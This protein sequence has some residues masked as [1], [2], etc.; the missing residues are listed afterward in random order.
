MLVLN[1]I[2]MALISAA[3]VGLLVWS[4]VTQH[5][6]SGCEH[7]RFSRRLRISVSFVPLDGPTS[8][9]PRRV[10]PSSAPEF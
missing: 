8:P 10:D 5:R 3:I 1:I 7:L 4:V 6:D 2:L 9:L